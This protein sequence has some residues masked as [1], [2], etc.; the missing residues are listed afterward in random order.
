MEDLRL[1]RIAKA[2]ETVKRDYEAAIAR[3][4]E[5]FEK[6]SAKATAEY[7]FRN[8]INLKLN[9]FEIKYKEGKYFNR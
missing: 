2:R 9:Y 3:N 6:G 8:Q 5:Q 1:R 4:D 7:I